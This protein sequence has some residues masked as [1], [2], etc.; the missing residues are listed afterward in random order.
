MRLGYTPIKATVVK[1]NEPGVPRPK[2]VY[3]SDN[4]PSDEEELRAYQAMHEGRNEE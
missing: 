1:K 3:D 4:E 2:G